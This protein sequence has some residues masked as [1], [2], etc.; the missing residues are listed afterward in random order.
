MRAACSLSTLVV[1]CVSAVALPACGRWGFD[2]SRA[3]LDGAGSDDGMPS[4]GPQSDA[5]VDAMVTPGTMTVGTTTV[6]ASSQNTSNNRVWASRSSMSQAGMMQRLVAY[7]GTG[8]GQ[9]TNVRGLIYRDAAGLPTT[10][11]G[12]TL[13]VALP[14]QTADGWV[15]LMF[16]TPVA[17]TA[18]MYWVGIQNDSSLQIAFQLGIG[19]TKNTTDAYA[20]GADAVYAGGSQTFM[21]EL[22]I[23]GEY[24]P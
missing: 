5:A 8:G 4:D 23:Y 12:E 21:M 20:D 6:G 17:L 2:E 13:A 7:V 9:G 11:V 22:S 16:A 24:I 19:A 3:V 1:A 18:G 15:S 14:A 10:L